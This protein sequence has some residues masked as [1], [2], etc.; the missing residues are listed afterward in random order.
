MGRLTGRA[1][2]RLLPLALSHRVLSLVVISSSP[3]T[4]GDR[5]LPGPTAKLGRFIASAAVDWSDSESV[6]E[7]QVKYS[8]MRAGDRRSFDEEARPCAR[9][10]RCRASAGLNGAANHD[11]TPDDDRSYHALASIPSPRS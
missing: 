2:E 7:Y 10:A 1:L 11:A 6:V 9:P 5:G 3:A 8:G 4:P